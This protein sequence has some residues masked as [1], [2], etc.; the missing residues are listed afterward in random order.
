M[1]GTMKAI[2]IYEY[3]GPEVLRLE[4]LPTPEPGPGQALVQ[5]AAVGVNFVD[6]YNRMGWYKLPLLPAGIGGEGAGQVVAV[7]HDVTEVKPGD[8]VAWL[9]GA[10]GYAS[11]LTIT[12]GKLAP[13]PDTVT[14]EQAAAAMVQGVTAHVL[15][16]RTYGVKEGDWI[17]VHAA[18]GGVGR[19][20]CQMARRAGAHVIGTVSSEAK[21]RVAAE[22]GAAHTI[23]Y[24]EHDFLVEVRRITGGK[25]VNAVYDSVGKDT[26]DRSLDSLAP[27]GYLVLF[28]QSS[29]FPPPFDIQRL[30]GPRSLFLTRPSVFA[31]VSERHSLLHHADAV[32]GMLETGDLTLHIDRKYP[33]EEAAQAHIDLAGR[34]TTGKLLLIP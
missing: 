26:F 31:Y 12:A 6:I 21:A 4:H 3:G 1:E 23:N 9:G 32:F 5:A 15:T 24:T 19:L 11:H 22:A 25:G 20:L 30:A 10:G 2:R 17:L 7:A 28:G 29:G 13:V 16:T 14:A 8:R 18:A 27:L 34:K 33:L